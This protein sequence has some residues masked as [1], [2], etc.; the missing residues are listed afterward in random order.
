MQDV[1]ILL[2]HN[3]EKQEISLKGL[4]VLFA[5]E[6]TVQTDRPYHQVFLGHGIYALTV[7]F[8]EISIAHRIAVTSHRHTSMRPISALRP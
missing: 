1:P 4:N 2:R 6:P 8:T 3:L 5:E 7:E